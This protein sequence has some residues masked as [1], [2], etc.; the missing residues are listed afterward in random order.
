MT[1]QTIAVG[2]SFFT[3][4]RLVGVTVMPAALE[5][6]V[7]ILCIVMPVSLYPLSLF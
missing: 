5:D 6:F 2:F 1:L 4:T 7:S 3:F